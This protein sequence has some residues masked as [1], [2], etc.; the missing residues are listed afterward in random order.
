MKNLH[1]QFSDE[2]KQHLNY[3]GSMDWETQHTGGT[4]VGGHL[5]RNGE[6]RALEGEPRRREKHRLRKVLR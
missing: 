2:E 4:R 3:L 5:G 6:E 1:E